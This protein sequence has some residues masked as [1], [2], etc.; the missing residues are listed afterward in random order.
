VVTGITT[1]LAVRSGR[2]ATG[3]VAVAAAVLSGQLTVGWTNDLVDRHRDRAAGRTD[4]PLVAGTIEPGTVRLAAWLALLACVP[5]S[6]LSGWRAG[7]VHLGAVAMGLAYDLRLKATAASAVPWLVAFAAL[8]A[9]VTL[10]LPRPVVPP[11]WA[12]A[13]SGLLG[14]GAHFLNALP[15]L[16]DDS[17]LGVSGLPHRLGPGPTLAAGALL[18]SASA[19]VLVLGPPG[20]PGVGASVVGAATLAVVGLLVVAARRGRPRRAWSLVLVT[21][22]LAV[23]LLVARGAALAGTTTG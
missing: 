3:V 23:G 20:L 1:A 5:L 21:A 10:G 7:L 22:A 19:L 16:E 8:P 4:K 13:A 15:D 11:W 9:F 18:L 6:L 12:M 17:R 2:D 14:G